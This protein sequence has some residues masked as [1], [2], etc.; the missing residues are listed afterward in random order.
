MPKTLALKPMDE[1]SSWNAKFRSGSHTSLDPDPLLITAWSEYI[2]PLLGSSDQRRVLDVAGGVGRHA[3]YLAEHGWKATLID[4][5]DK[6]IEIAKENAQQRQ[7][8]IDLRNEDLRFA[9]LGS[10]AYELI[11]VF[12]YLQKELFPALTR[13]L[14]P[15]GI[16][17]YKTYTQDHPR[18]SGGKGP[19]HPMHLLEPNELLK[20]FSS[21]QA[22]FYRETV[23]E[24]GIAELVARK[25]R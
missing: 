2:E 5:S 6:G 11:L 9:E 7:L 17:V 24:K 3:L 10:E 13:A 25:L 16:L 20:A 4:V 23:Q 19:T 22:L 15:G 8:K 12:F 14:A 21:M 1:R 18:L